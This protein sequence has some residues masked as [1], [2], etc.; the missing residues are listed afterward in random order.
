MIIMRIRVIIFY[1]FMFFA[2][3]KINAE[4]NEHTK[5]FNI[6][7]IEY[8]IKVISNSLGTDI[9]ISNKTFFKNITEEIPGEN[10]FPNVF[11]NK[12]NYIVT[13]IQYEKNNVKLC[14]YD[15]L[16]SRSHIIISDKFK[17]IG[18]AKP[19]YWEEKLRAL[20]FIGLKG[21][22]DD[23]YCYDIFNEKYKN[24][25][26]TKEFEKNFLVTVNNN[27]FFLNIETND[28]KSEYFINPEN[29]N[30]KQINN[31]KKIK[32]L[33]TTTKKGGG[34]KYFNNIIAFG[35]SIIWGKIRMDEYKPPYIEDWTGYDYHP[36]LTFWG[37]LAK[38]FNNNYGNVTTVNLGVPRDTALD[39]KNRM[40]R[41]F[42]SINGYFCLIMFGTND[43]GNNYTSMESVVE[44]LEWIVLNARDSYDMLPIISTIP[45][46]QLKDEGSN[47]QYFI[48]NTVLLNNLIIEMAKKNNINY[49]DSYTAIMN[50]EEGWQECLEDFRGNHPS[51]LGHKYMAEL[52]KPIILN[53]NPESPSGIMKNSSGINNIVLSWNSN[54]EFDFSH[55][56]VNYGFYPNQLNRTFNTSDSTYIFYKNFVNN[57]FQ[58]KLYIQLQ[59]VDKDGNNSE[60]TEIFTF[61][62]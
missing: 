37:Q 13:W 32:P 54:I 57:S 30:I 9:I 23:V 20:F 35:D 27:E 21:D 49:I 47:V 11:V 33:I 2:F 18:N 36:E 59:S 42:H 34:Y 3:F 55:Y 61:D 53:I 39:G 25:T 6:N 24:I 48:D 51:P 28:L 26:E 43:V 15:S 31:I 45:P 7:G 62:R 12:N 16:S 4:I 29:L 52:V 41:D 17:F 60:F 5:L 8:S 10:L 56:K 38:D 14:L 40:N 46:I 1:V 58:S 22:N 44:N 19:V 50:S